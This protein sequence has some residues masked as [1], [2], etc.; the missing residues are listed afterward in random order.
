GIGKSRLALQI[1]GELASAFADGAVFVALAPVAAAETVPAVIAEAL[2]ISLA[3]GDAPFEQLL[4]TLRERELLLV[5]DNL[6]HLLDAT[7]PGH[8]RGDRLPVAAARGRRAPGPGA[9]E[10][11]SR[12]PPPHGGCRRSAE[13]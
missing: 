3:G 2:D 12:R 1:A 4:A 8:G 6:E 5:L 13:V 9:A 10:R 7:P 11:F